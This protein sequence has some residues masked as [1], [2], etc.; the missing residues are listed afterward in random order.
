MNIQLGVSNHY[1]GNHNLKDETGR[2]LF[3]MLFVYILY[4]L[5]DVS[6]GVFFLMRLQFVKM[7]WNWTL[8]EYTDDTYSY[9]FAFVVSH[10]ITRVIRVQKRAAQCFRL[11][12]IKPIGRKYIRILVIIIL[13]ILFHTYRTVNCRF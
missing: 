13:K 7:K 11:L 6:F 3:Y 2:G 5:V 10:W 1:D 9:T 8:Y 4:I 12:V